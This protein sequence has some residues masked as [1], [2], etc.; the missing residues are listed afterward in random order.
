M[1]VG[2][3]QK[4]KWNVWPCL[5]ASTIWVIERLHVLEIPA[6]RG[7]WDPRST[8]KIYLMKIR[9]QLSAIVDIYLTK[10]GQNRLA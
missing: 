2:S 1:M 7:I 9:K 4:K 10:T 6:Y 8:V 3:F 5:A